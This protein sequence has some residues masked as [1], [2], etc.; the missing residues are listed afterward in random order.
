MLNPELVL[1]EFEAREVALP[2]RAY[3]LIRSRYAGRIDVS[4]TERP[5]VYR[6]AARDYVGRVGLPGGLLLVIRPK[7]GAAN[8]FYMLMSEPGLARFFPPPTG[9]T[10]STEIFSFVAQL[11][12]QKV[13][14]LFRTGLYRAF[15]SRQ[16]DL[17]FVRGRIAIGAQLH[18]YGELKNRHICAY[19]DLTPDTV[20]N[21]IVAATLRLL[22]LLLRHEAEA[23][24]VKR[25][26]ALLP[27][28]DEVRAVTRGE[29]LALLPG[30]AFHRLNAAYAPLLALC[31]L[32]LQRLTLDERPGPHPFASFLVDMPR[33]FESFV[34]ERLRAHLAP[35]GL[36][37]TAQRHDYLDVGRQVGIR[38]D[39]LV[40]PVG[41]PDPVLV[42]DAKYSQLNGAQNGP[43]QPS[44][45][46]LNRDLYQ[47]SAYMDRYRLR[48]GALVY[49]QFED[50]TQ[51]EHRLRGTSKQIHL[52]TLDLSARQ[53]A[54]LEQHCAALAE[55]VARLALDGHS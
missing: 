46:D 14:E 36:R 42:L 10:P 9:L 21:R 55:R 4:I 12:V 2:A 41:G 13:E 6:V 31:R 28:F 51:V 5:G 53:P 43:T 25:A 54:E 34:T 27:R 33:L 23:G 16:D 18:R 3:A 52:L 8:L 26:R 35:H 49:P 19:A 40:Y 45:H 47:V 37:V 20:E 29:A 38:P 48:R 15:V 50:V 30:T 24:L 7:V 1:K 44:G 22:P 32:V 11:L 39:V 17:P